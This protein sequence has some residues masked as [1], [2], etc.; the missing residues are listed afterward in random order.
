[1]A[2]FESKK[3]SYSDILVG[4]LPYQRALEQGDSEVRASAEREFSLLARYELL[5]LAARSAGVTIRR[6]DVGLRGRKFDPNE[7]ERVVTRVHAQYSAAIAVAG[8]ASAT[9]AVKEF[10]GRSDI[11]DS[12]VRAERRY[13][14]A[15]KAFSAFLTVER[16]MAKLR[17]AAESLLLE[18]ALSDWVDKESKRRGIDRDELAR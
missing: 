8:G 4:G 16:E 5:V 10:N 14:G 17:M 12:M 13:P 1:M 15:L 9:E 6:D 18:E 11:L 3:I 2:T 7:V